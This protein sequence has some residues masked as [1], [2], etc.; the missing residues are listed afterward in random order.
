MEKKSTQN[1][2]L[3]ANDFCP[4][5]SVFPPHLLS[6][7]YEASLMSLVNM[8]YIGSTAVNQLEFALNP[9]TGATFGVMPLAEMVRINQQTPRTKNSSNEVSAERKTQKESSRRRRI[10]SS[11]NELHEQ[12]RRRRTEEVGQNQ[13]IDFLNLTGNYQPRLFG[14]SSVWLLKT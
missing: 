14:L 6:E 2:N 1:G 10:S 8:S 11:S 12:T 7:I 3:H 4:E 13:Q 5:K 9:L